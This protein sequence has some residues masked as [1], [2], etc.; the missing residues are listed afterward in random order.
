M[1]DRNMLLLITFLILTVTLIFFLSMVDLFENSLFHLSSFRNYT[2]IDLDRSIDGLQ[3]IKISHPHSKSHP[4]NTALNEVLIPELKQVEYANFQVELYPDSQLGP[5]KEQER[6]LEHG[7]IEIS[8]IPAS[9][10][11]AAA[12]LKVFSIPYMFRDFSEVE[13]FMS[14]QNNSRIIR[15]ELAHSNLVLLGWGYE[16]YRHIVQTRVA[17]GSVQPNS[18]ALTTGGSPLSTEFFQEKQLIPTFLSPEDLEW[19]LQNGTVGYGELSTLQFN[20]RFL[21]QKIREVT[22]IRYLCIPSLYLANAEFWNSLAAEEKEAV[23]KAVSKTIVQA[24]RSIGTTEHAFLEEMGKGFEE[25]G[26]NG[27]YLSRVRNHADFSDLIFP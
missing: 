17:N 5:V 2:H 20:E 1:K 8:V 18:I 3:V 4:I 24:N 27:D 26:V 11:R 21:A 19:Q 6:G 12:S 16:G 13:E 10:L 22:Y 23:Q 14:D 9:D 7:A 15:E 25:T